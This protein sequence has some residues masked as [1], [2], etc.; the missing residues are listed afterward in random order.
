[1]FLLVSFP[2][3]LSSSIWQQFLPN[4]QKL[5]MLLFLFTFMIILIL[6]KMSLQHTYSQC[7]RLTNL[8]ITFV[9]N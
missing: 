9:V 7:L 4:D 6:I 1:M 2:S 5:D 8:A 3:W